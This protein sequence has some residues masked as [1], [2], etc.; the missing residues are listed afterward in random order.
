[1]PTYAPG[2]RSDPAPLK[3]GTR[4]ALGSSSGNLT[5]ISLDEMRRREATGSNSLYGSEALARYDMDHYGSA[6]T[7]T[8]ADYVKYFNELVPE[9]GGNIQRRLLADATALGKNREVAAEQVAKSGEAFNNSYAGAQ[10]NLQSAIAAGQGA[11]SADAQPGADATQPITKNL[12][13]GRDASAAALPYYGMAIQEA[14]DEKMKLLNEAAEGDI[15]AARS[16]QA[17]NIL[18]LAMQQVAQDEQ[19][20]VDERN[21]LQ[22]RSDRLTDMRFQE[23]ADLRAAQREE[24]QYQ[25]RLVGEQ[26]LGMGYEGGATAAD[27]DRQ[28]AGYRYAVQQLSDP[29]TFEASKASSPIDFATI[30]AGP[31]G[32]KETVTSFNRDTYL[33]TLASKNPQRLALLAADGHLTDEELAKYLKIAPA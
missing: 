32:G 8:E 23:E 5:Q 2:R 31:F 33:K 17:F 11:I 13:R 16:E 3:P 4:S 7:P 19:R 21:R 24:E 30:G 1:M 9:A 29:S 27:R 20:K 6:S 26:L 28:S 22:A 25:N 10:S 18:Q 15:G 12:A 14:Y